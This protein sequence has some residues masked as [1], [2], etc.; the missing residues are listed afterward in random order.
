MLVAEM[1][2]PIIDT[3][4]LGVES[5]GSLPRLLERF[6]DLTPY[7]IDFR[8]TYDGAY[9]PGNGTSGAGFCIWSSTGVLLEE[10]A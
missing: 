7:D 5:T 6:V 9:N 1:V 8:L 4:L 2:K 10:H 3:R